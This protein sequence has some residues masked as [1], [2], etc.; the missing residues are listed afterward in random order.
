MR[1]YR[2]A[3]DLLLVPRES[4]G[5]QQEDLVWAFRPGTAGC[6]DHL[7]GAVEVGRGMPSHRRLD[8]EAATAQGGDDHT[9]ELTGG[10]DYEVT[11]RGEDDPT[12]PG[13]APSSAGV[14]DR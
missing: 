14:S 4:V 1:I 2:T 9:G 5:Q 12:A 6:G 3:D 11:V 13:D 8:A 10:L 7:A